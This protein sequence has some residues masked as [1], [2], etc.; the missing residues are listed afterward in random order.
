MVAVPEKKASP[1]LWVLLGCG[2]AIFLAVAV[3][4]G[5]VLIAIPSGGH[6]GWSYNETNAVGS[7]RT[8]A[9]AQ[10]MFRRADW[11]KNGV[12]EY[13]DKMPA[14]RFTKDSGGVEM[15]LLNAEL[16]AAH[17]ANGTPRHGYLFKE[18]S[19]LTGSQLD[20]VNDYAL[21]ALPAVYGKTG[22][23]TF[24]ISTDGTVYARDQGEGGSFVTD[25]PTDPS[26][27]GWAIAE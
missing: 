18:M 24:I 1:L 21:C 11:N 14:L 15:E 12:C 20:W 23:R 9:S 10:T 8:Y 2:A 19:T 16:A 22:K 4:V 26:G 3:V 6:P 13:A 27:A 25:Y 17:G 7:L 5:V